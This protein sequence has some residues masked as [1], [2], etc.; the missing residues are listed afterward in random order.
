VTWLRRAALD[1]L[2]TW[3][4]LFGLIWLV[5]TVEV[6][7]TYV[8]GPVNSGDVPETVPE[9]IMWSAVIGPYF[10]VLA[11]PWTLPAAALVG[12]GSAWF[13]SR[14]AARTSPT[15]YRGLPRAAALGDPSRSP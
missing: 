14:H 10:N 11:L 6:C 3:S 15:H 9:A 1:G 5:I 12:A 2:I 4:A 8:Q 13:W 7:F